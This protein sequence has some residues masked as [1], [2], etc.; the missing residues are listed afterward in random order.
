[1]NI[2]RGLDKNPVFVAI[3]AFTVVVQYL[4][5]EVSQDIQ[6]NIVG[7]H[8]C[9]VF[10]RRADPCRM[11]AFATRLASPRLILP[12]THPDC[13]SCCLALLQYGGEFTRTEPLTAEEWR[14]TVLLG[15]YASE[16]AS[17]RAIFLSVRGGVEA[18][19][20]MRGRQAGRRPGAGSMPGCMA[21]RHIP[22]P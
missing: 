2:F 8:G 20:W 5:V 7:G 13:S 18:D 3:I 15:K 21:G 9:R 16:R 12:P 19:G 10:A 22:L 17:G 1:M 14:A 6:T 11:H 4:V